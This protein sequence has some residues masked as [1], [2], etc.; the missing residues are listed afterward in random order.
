LAIFYSFANGSR[1]GDD[2]KRLD[3]RVIFVTFRRAADKFWQRNA[4]EKRTSFSP[5]FR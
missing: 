4:P 2:F 3:S 1:Y 5:R